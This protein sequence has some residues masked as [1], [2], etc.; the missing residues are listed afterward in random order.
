M[1]N[2]TSSANMNLTAVST[3]SAVYCASQV[4]Y[5]DAGGVMRPID[6]ANQDYGF[7]LLPIGVAEPV[8][9]EEAAPADQWPQK[10]APAVE[11]PLPDRWDQL[12]I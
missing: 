1:P 9:T 12:E 3:A 7:A 8:Q 6:H 10:I 11:E 4:F 5:V 2:F